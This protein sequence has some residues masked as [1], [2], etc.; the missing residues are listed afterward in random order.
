MEEAVECIVYCYA[1]WALWFYSFPSRMPA[2]KRGFPYSANCRSPLILPFA[3]QHINP[4][5]ATI[6][7]SPGF[8]QG[9]YD[10][11]ISLSE[12]TPYSGSR[13]PARNYGGEFILQGIKLPTD[14]FYKLKGREFKH[15]AD[16]QSYAAVEFTQRLP[17]AMWTLKGLSDSIIP[18][19]LNLYASARFTVMSY[20][21]SFSSGLTLPPQALP[22]RGQKWHP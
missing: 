15:A 12:T 2:T 20:M 14:D 18:L 5:M 11:H 21:R 13:K 3:P 4:E 6:S 10:I 7:L 8:E 1:P 9:R 19:W 16:E 17:G 22:I